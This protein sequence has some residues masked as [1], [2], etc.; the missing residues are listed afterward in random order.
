MM[1]WY[2][3]VLASSIPAGYLIA[4]C[5]REELRVGRNWFERL[6]IFSGAGAL[7]AWGYG[8]TNDVVLLLW[9]M[10]VGGIGYHQSFNTKWTKSKV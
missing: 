8:S 2:L 3:L 7:V 1:L 10:V 6:V 5:A 9:V 4:W